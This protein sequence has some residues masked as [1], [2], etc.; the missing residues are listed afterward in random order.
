VGLVR[1]LDKEGSI[2]LEAPSDG[3]DE[4]DDNADDAGDDADAC[5]D[6]D[7]KQEQLRTG[8]LPMKGKPRFYRVTDKCMVDLVDGSQ[9]Y[10]FSSSKTQDLF[11]FYIRKSIDSHREVQVLMV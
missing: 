2:D 11:I 10:P 7:V 5:D 9:A 4:E 8:I 3:D 1:G 6:N